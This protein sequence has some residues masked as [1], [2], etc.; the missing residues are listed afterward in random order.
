MNV[1]MVTSGAPRPFN[2]AGTRAYH[3]LKSLAGAHTVS[4]LALMDRAE[5]VPFS[6]QDIAALASPVRLVDL[7]DARSKRLRQAFS[8]LSGR[9]FA[10]TVNSPAMAQSIIDE[11]VASS[12]I[13]VVVFERVFVAGY[14]LPAHVGVVL[15]Q[16]NIEHELVERSVAQATSRVRRFYG[17]R[18]A[19]HLRRGELERCERADAIAVCSERERALLA[20]LLP[21]KLITVAPNGVDLAAFPFD[22]AADEVPGRIIFTGT[23]HYQPNTQAALTFARLCWP[24]IHEQEPSATWHIVGAGAPPE[25]QALGKLPGVTVTG[26]TPDVHPHLAAANVAIAPL[27]V[28][29]GTRLKIL[30][31]FATG[32]AVVSTALGCEGI[33]VTPG[34]HLL[35]EDD[36]RRFGDAVVTLLRDAQRRRELGAQ[37]HALVKAQYSWDASGQRLA[38]VVEAVAARK[39]TQ[40]RSLPA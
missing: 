40:R 2:G 12:A 15:D 5:K 30:E 24:R 3:L 28:G 8:L 17:A 33:D 11:L 23:M 37:G 10:L 38:Q 13:D 1:L 36:M 16:H 34:V 6:P 26:W 4:L 32:K 21:G 20:D 27:S 14:R 35:V 22:A 39:R 25:V 18:E 9:S 31:A 19:R 29:G 7:P